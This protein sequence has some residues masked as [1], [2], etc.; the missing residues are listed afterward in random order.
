M[1]GSEQVPTHLALTPIKIA[2]DLGNLPPETL[3]FSVMSC[4]I[5]T[6]AK[7]IYPLQSNWQ[8][9]HDVVIVHEYGV[10]LCT[11][12]AKYYTGTGHTPC[13]EGESASTPPHFLGSHLRST[14]GALPCGDGHGVLGHGATQ[15]SQ[16]S[17]S[18]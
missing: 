1:V 18:R 10:S 13:S 11:V 16:R 12:A 5:A 14:A 4:T 15:P 17:S 3:R 8:G 9:V 7:L 2:A 6:V